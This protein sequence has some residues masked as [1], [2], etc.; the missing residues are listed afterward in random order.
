M[1][2]G[3]TGFDPTIDGLQRNLEEA[4]EQGFPS[5]W[6]PQIFGLDALTA[7]AVAGRDVDIRIGTAV[8]PTYPRHP[9]MLAQQA[10]TTQAAINGR[11][12]LGI[13]LSHK[14]VVE[15]M[16]GISFDKPVGHLRDYLNVLM[17]LLH[18]RR[19]SYG[20]EYVTGRG[21]ITP[22]PAAAPPV[23]VA[24]LGPQ[25]LKL[26][27]RVADG[28]ITWMTGPKT[29]ADLTVP[30]ISEAA[31]D[32]GQPAPQ[33]IASFPVCVTDDVA[34]ARERAAKEFEI[35]GQLPSY[36]SMLDHEGLE[37]PA[38]LAIISSAA[39]VHDRVSALAGAGVTT[40]TAAAFGSAGELEATRQAMIDLL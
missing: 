3:I 38:D 12:E 23:L 30:T 2:I 11:L 14:P 18:D 10:L 31:A 24:A 39:E 20:G 4:A 27:G 16:W 40:M 22:P 32:A 8:I 9:M 36:R 13:G 6:V 34:S 19:V 28:T 1:Q 21:E 37:G 5:Y 25:M 7:F 35:Y 29:L 33:I 26:T 17:P 15:G